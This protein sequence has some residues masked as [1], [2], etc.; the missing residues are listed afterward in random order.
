MGPYTVFTISAFGIL[1][2][3]WLLV[4]EKESNAACENHTTEGGQPG[5]SL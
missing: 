5:A 1:K 2:T 3:T 4:I